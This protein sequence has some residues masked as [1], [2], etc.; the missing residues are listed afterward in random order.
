MNEDV[1]AVIP[2]F[3]ES[4]EIAK[5]VAGV[6]HFCKN[7][8][9]VDDGSTDRTAHFAKKAKVIKLIINSGKGTALRT[10]CDYAIQEGAK[11]IVVVDADGQHNPKEIPNFIKALDKYDI[12]FGYREFTK[13]MPKVLRLGNWG[14]SLMTTIIQR[15]KLKDTQCGYRAFTAKAYKKVRWKST[16]YSMES[17][18]IARASRA[19][20]KYTEVKVDTIYNDNY[21]GTT[22]FDG[23]GV[24]KDII[25]WRF[26]I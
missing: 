20:L 2:A 11:K 22:A 16:G 18:M 9:V 12:V 10:G 13:A 25:K 3:N 26:E 7:V 17:E 19:K 14:L 6:K 24:M 23:V 8:V 5:T 1:W 21:K 15:I 4:K